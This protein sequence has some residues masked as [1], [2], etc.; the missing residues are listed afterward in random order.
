[1]NEPIN[2]DAACTDGSCGKTTKV[3]IDREHAHVAGNW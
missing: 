1:M 2:A 3:I